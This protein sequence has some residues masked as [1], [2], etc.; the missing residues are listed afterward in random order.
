MAMHSLNYF[1]LFDHI[2]VR[3]R[4]RRCPKI[5]FFLFR[6]FF[7][8]NSKLICEDYYIEHLKHL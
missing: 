3:K 1:M 6:L 4:V 8:Y 7:N 2:K 5:A